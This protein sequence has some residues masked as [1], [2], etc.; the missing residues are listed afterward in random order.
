MVSNLGRCA[1]GL[2]CE[3]DD[4]CYPINNNGYACESHAACYSGNC[5]ED[6]NCAPPEECSL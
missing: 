1:A 3:E 2:V 5:G 6:Y 4:K